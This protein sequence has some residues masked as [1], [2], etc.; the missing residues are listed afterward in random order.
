VIGVPASIDNDINGTN[1]SIG[2]DT[3]LNV[4]MDALDRIRDTATSHT[5]A[6]IIEVMGR[7]CGDLAITA[8]LIGGRKSSSPQN[9][10]FPWRK[11][12]T[13]CRT[14]IRVGSRMQSQ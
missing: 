11:L 7:N 8:A 12:L 3:A 5:R 9:N 10:M 2:V 4:I 6:F 13:P 1:M 14:L